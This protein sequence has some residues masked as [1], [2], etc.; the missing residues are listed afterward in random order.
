MKVKIPKHRTF[1]KKTHSN[2]TMNVNDK[3]YLEHEYMRFFLDGDTN[4]EPEFNSYVYNYIKPI[5]EYNIVW[6]ERVNKGKNILHVRNKILNSKSEDVTRS[7]WS[8][9]HTT[10]CINNINDFNKLLS[11]DIVDS[12]VMINFESIGSKVNIPDNKILK[13]LGSLELIVRDVDDLLI[14]SHIITKKTDKWSYIKINFI[15]DN[16]FLML[17]FVILNRTYN[18]HDYIRLRNIDGMNPININPGVI[19]NKPLAFVRNYTDKLIDF[20]S[21]YEKRIPYKTIQRLFNMYKNDA[22]LYERICDSLR[23]TD[24]V[25]YLEENIKLHSEF[26]KMMDD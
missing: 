25:Y 17:P 11:F 16:L 5:F 1:N 10:I 14:F 20:L 6:N 22:D 24:N 19:V 3:F 7:T 15:D 18:K 9:N 13:I 26:K 12:H 4:S 2:L 21:T 8:D 23:D